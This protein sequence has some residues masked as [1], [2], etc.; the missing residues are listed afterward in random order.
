MSGSRNETFSIDITECFISFKIFLSLFQ[1]TLNTNLNYFFIQIIPSAHERMNGIIHNLSSILIE[2]KR[3]DSTSFPTTIG[4]SDE[5]QAHRTPRFVCIFPSSHPDPPD[6]RCLILE[7]KQWSR[8]GQQSHRFPRWQKC[9]ADFPW[10]KW[11]WREFLRAMHLA[12]RR[13]PTI[14]VLWHAPR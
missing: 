4:S 7:W 1:N 13:P 6:L 2:W 12:C 14:H 3:F 10:R 8:K 11:W 5:P 9:I